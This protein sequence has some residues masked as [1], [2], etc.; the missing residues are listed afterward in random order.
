MQQVWNHIPGDDTR[1]NP[2]ADRVASDAVCVDTELVGVWHP[3][4][5]PG[6]AVAQPVDPATP[7]HQHLQLDQHVDRG[8][9]V[10]ERTQGRAIWAAHLRRVRRADH[11]RGQGS[12]RQGQGDQV[13]HRPQGVQEDIVQREFQQEVGDSQ[14]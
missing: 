7:L 5:Q 9:L 11:A 10:Q 2:Q 13:V 3:R 4:A 12:V 8:G 14:H 6:P 1:L